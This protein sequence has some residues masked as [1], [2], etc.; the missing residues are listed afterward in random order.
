MILGKFLP[1]HAGHQR[2]I[3]FGLEFCERLHVL[4]CTLHREPIPGALRYAWMRELFPDGV[5]HHVTDDLPQEPS[6]HPHFWEIWRETVSRAVGEPIDYVFA[7]EAYGY[8]LAEELQATFVPVDVARSSVP[9]SGTAIRERPLENWRFLPECVRPY[10]ARRVCIFGPEST[11]KSTLA[12]ALARRFQTVHV[13][14]F[15]RGWLDRK[16]GVCTVEDI[17]IIARGQAAAEDSLVRYANRALICDTD[18]LLT[19]I[20]SETLFGDCPAWIR[21]EAL[22]RQYDLY[23]LLDVDVAWID[24]SQRYLP[25]RRQEFFDT[26]R[27]VLTQAGRPFLVV[28]GDWERRFE[29]A[30]EAVESLLR[31]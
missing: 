11:G 14:E 15:A 26:C 8:R 23:L 7:S 31:E 9:I 27:R 12:E 19:T 20:W 10:Y 5:L 24:D 13:A 1:P 21:E 22:R 30:C 3:R 16:Q 2:L 6:E 4:V 28:R 18:L 25:H 29:I 17:P